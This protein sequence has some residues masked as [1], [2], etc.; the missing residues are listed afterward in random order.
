MERRAISLAEGDLEDKAEQARL[1]DDAGFEVIWSSGGSIPAFGVMVASV[2][3][4]KVGTG[5][6]RAFAHDL[7]NLS[8]HAADLH[9]LSGGRFILGL[10]G[11]TKRMNINQLGQ[12]FDHP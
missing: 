10:G 3:K 11:G 9:A 4:H 5:V 1:A 6:I 7:R 8:L 12:E 2:A